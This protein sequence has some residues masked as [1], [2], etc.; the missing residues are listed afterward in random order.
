M[1]FNGTISQK[2]TKRQR[3]RKKTR[4]MEKAVEERT[5]KDR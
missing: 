4:N 3:G 5:R 2:K 1:Q